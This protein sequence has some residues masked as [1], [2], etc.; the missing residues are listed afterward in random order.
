[1]KAAGSTSRIL[2]AGALNDV[3]AVRTRSWRNG[4]LIAKNFPVADVTEHLD[5]DSKRVVWV[6][7]CEPDRDQLL[8]L[9]EEL[10]LQMNVPW[11]GSG[12]T[13]GA[14]ASTALAVGIATGPYLH[15]RHRGR[16]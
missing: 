2:G 3:A 13:T 10:S 11:A 1:M 14:I 16:L 15:L 9:T 4:T 6:D 8:M 7:V 5:A 12:S